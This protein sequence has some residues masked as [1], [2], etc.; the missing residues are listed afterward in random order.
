MLNDPARLDDPLWILRHLGEDEVVQL[1]ERSQ[2]HGRPAL[3]L[4][5]AHVFLHRLDS[6]PVSRR[7]LFREFQNTGYMLR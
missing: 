7:E 1:M 5:T 6:S 2:L 4:A 3:A